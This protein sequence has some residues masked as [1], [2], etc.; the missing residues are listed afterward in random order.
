MD[1]SDGHGTANRALAKGKDR[2]VAIRM[3]HTV[4]S[5]RLGGCITGIVPNQLHS[6]FL[7]R[8]CYCDP[9]HSFRSFG[10]A[11]C[12]SECCS[13]PPH[14]ASSRLLSPAL[15]VSPHTQILFTFSRP[16]VFVALF[17]ALHRARLGRTVNSI[18]TDRDKRVKRDADESPALVC[19]GCEEVSSLYAKVKRQKRL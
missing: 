10:G 12:R 14:L 3:D 16:S 15:S 13:F 9:R 11:C 1:G 5:R 4:R 6:V 19:D 7:F 18:N 8:R 2:I 17:T